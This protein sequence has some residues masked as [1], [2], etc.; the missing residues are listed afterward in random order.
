MNAELLIPSAA[1]KPYIRNYLVIESPEGLANRVLPD[2]SLVMAFRFK[3]AISYTAD[4][5]ESDLPLSVISGLRNTARVINYTQNSGAVLVIFKAAATPAFFKISA[6]EL[7]NDSIPLDTLFNRQKLVQ[8][9]ERLAAAVNNEQ[10]IAAIEELLLAQLT[11]LTPDQLI[12]SAVQKISLNQGCTRIRDL[13]SSLYISQDAFEKRFRKATG[14]SPK[15]YSSIIRMRSLLGNGKQ[16]LNLNELAFTAG[17][18]DQPHFNKDF[19]LFT[20]L[21]PT[22]FYK[23]PVFW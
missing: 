15:Q 23:A 11:N 20:G 10:R 7:F 2:T 8:T 21:T 17:Y 9:E 19:R 5:K 13:A 18:F 3:G 22:D 14:A 1:L 4:G 12:L 6:H 16:T